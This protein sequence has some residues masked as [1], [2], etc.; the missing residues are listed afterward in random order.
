M[1]RCSSPL[2]VLSG[3]GELQQNLGAEVRDGQPAESDTSP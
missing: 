2:L 1:E 3:L